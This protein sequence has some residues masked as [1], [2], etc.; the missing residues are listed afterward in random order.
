MVFRIGFRI[1]KH[2]LKIDFNSFVSNVM[3]HPTILHY[4]TVVKTKSEETIKKDV[5]VDLPNPPSASVTLI[6]QLTGF[7]RRATLALNG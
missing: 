7:Y 5:A 3:A 6:N 1:Q 2:V 4:A